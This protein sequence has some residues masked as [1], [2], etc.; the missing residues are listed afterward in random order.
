MNRARGEQERDAALA[1]GEVAEATHGRFSLVGG[2]GEVGCARLAWRASRIVERRGSTVVEVSS[3]SSWA[4]SSRSWRELSS[5]NRS[6]RLAASGVARD[7][8]LAAIGRV[9]VPAAGARARRAGRPGRWPIDEP[10]PQ[11]RGELGHAQLAGGQH[12]VQDLGLG[13][14]D[15]DLGEL[16][17][18]ARDQAVHQR[19]VA[20]RRRAS[21]VG[22]RPAVGRFVSAEM[23]GISVLFGLAAHYIGCGDAARSGP[24]VPSRR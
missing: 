23:F 10:T 11:A 19:V 24:L 17:R 20:R 14:G 22:R 7:D 8:D 1:D 3:A 16:R 5:R 15:P 9:V 21:M 6:R 4:S 2:G 18:V 13:H 12:D